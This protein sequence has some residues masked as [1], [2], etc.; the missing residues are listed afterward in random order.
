MHHWRTLYHDSIRE[1]DPIVLHRLVYQ[2]EE[3]MYER[4]KK[5]NK[6]PHRMAELLAMQHAVDDLLAIKTDRLGWPDPFRY[7]LR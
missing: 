1:H 7:H 6:N 4:W 3:A 5:L 2:I